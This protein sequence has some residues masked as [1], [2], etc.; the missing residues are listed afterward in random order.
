MARSILMLFILCCTFKHGYSQLIPFNPCPNVFQYLKDDGM[1]H[2][3]VEFANDGSGLYVLGVN[4]SVAVFLDNEKSI[5]LHLLTSPNDIANGAALVYNIYFPVENVIP[6]PTKIVFNNVVY[7]S[8]LPAKL[9]PGG[10]VTNLWADTYL[11]ITVSY[12]NTDSSIYKPTPTVFRPTTPQPTF[13][14]TPTYINY[15]ECGVTNFKTRSLVVNGDDVSDGQFPWM[16]AVMYK[17]ADDFKYRC[18]GTLISKR[19]VVTAGHCLQ[20]GKV[21]LFA[22]EELIVVLGITNLE[23]WRAAGTLSDVE[24]FQTH[25]DFKE[26]SADGDLAIITLRT[27]VRFRETVRRACLWEES[28]DLDAVLNLEGTIAGWGTDNP[29]VEYSKDARSITLP[30]VSQTV[31]LRSDSGFQAITS[32]RTFCAGRRNNKGPC[33]GD[34]GAGFLMLRGGRW[35]LRGVTSLSLNDNISCDLDNYSVFVDV[36]KVKKWIKSILT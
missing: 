14:T 4:M 33:T 8:S 29:D 36:A 18:T 3:R 10:Y 35:T 2:G 19:H 20:Y 23:N 12:A 22:L 27:E 32:S 31:C 1:V 17:M 24:N 11:K 26:N 34:S 15:D 30:I 7:C 6:K 25:A 5:R 13:T 16:V 21:P 28:D 9:E